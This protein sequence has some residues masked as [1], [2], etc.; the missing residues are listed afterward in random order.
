MTAIFARDAKA[1]ESLLAD[2]YR[3]DIWECAALGHAAQLRDHLRHDRTLMERAGPGG[4]PPLHLA[5]HYGKLAA[6]RALLDEGA[7]PDTLGAPPLSNTAL[8]AAVA[9]A[10]LA[11]V[12]ALL[13]AGANPDITDASGNS[14]LHVAAAD[15][16]P[17]MV[18]AMLAKGAARDAKNAQGKTP[19]DFAI[20]RKHVEAAALLT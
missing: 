9:G 10:Q 14:A 15:G 5:A 4:F 11:A 2:G 17:E 16:T 13:D 18:R 7:S 12:R 8:H 20:E 3:P 6:M 19:R 1:I